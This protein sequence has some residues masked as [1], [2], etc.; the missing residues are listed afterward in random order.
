MANLVNGY[1]LNAVEQDAAR[2]GQATT[3]VGLKPDLRG[4]SHRH[5][6]EHVVSGNAWIQHV[7]NGDVINIRNRVDDPE[8]YPVPEVQGGL[9][10]RHRLFA[11]PVNAEHPGTALMFIDFMLDPRTRRK[12][13]EWTGYPMPT[14]ARR[15]RSRSWPRTTRSI[16]GHDRGPR[17]A[18]SSSP[19]STATTGRPGTAP[20]PRS[21]P[22][23]R[24]AVD[25]PT[26]AFAAA[27]RD[28]TLLPGRRGWSC[29]SRSRWRSRW[30][31]RSASTDEL[32]NAH[33]RLEPGELQP[34]V[35]PAVR[36]GA[37]ALGRLRARDRRPL[38]ADRLPGRLLHRPLR[39]PPQARC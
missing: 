26:S 25:E 37:A 33:L 19:T 13:V 12:N 6:H 22:P 27:L 8:H 9:P 4:F 5:D 31:S 20:G 10:G 7:W 35:R 36:A 38:P 39:R 15:S 32:G 21:R 18:A 16:A 11:I 2:R 24:G 3:L 30:R 1:E 23:D 28:L 14:R 17:Q 29:S 34:R